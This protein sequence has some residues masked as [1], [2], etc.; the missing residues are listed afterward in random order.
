VIWSAPVLMKTKAGPKILFGLGPMTFIDLEKGTIEPHQR[1]KPW[2]GR[3]TGLLPVF[4][5]LSERASGRFDLAESPGSDAEVVAGPRKYGW[6][7]IV[8]PGNLPVPFPG[9]DCGFVP[10]RR[11]I[12]SDQVFKCKWNMWIGVAVGLESRKEFRQESF[13]L[14]RLCAGCF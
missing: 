1:F 12:D 7:R 2:C 10:S 8:L 5:C 13:R 14:C 6:L 3:G 4:E 9:L 11:Q